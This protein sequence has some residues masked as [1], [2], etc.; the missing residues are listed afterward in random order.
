MQIIIDS[1]EDLAWNMATFQRDYSRS[2]FETR[3]TEQNTYV[4]LVNGDTLLGFPEYLAGNIGVIFGTLFASPIRK[5]KGTWD[6]QSYLDRNHANKIYR[7]QL[8]LY[9]RLVEEHS[10]EFILVR[11][12]HDLNTV[13]SSWENPSLDDSQPK[14][15]IVILMEG[16]EAIQNEDDIE[17][18]WNS[19]V[20][21][22]GPAWAGTVFCGGTR[23]PGALTKEG[24]RLLSKMNDCGFV[25]DISHMD[26]TAVMQAL[27]FYPGTIIAS[28]SNASA[29]IKAYS[30]NRHLS[31]MTI[32]RLLERDSTIGIIPYNVFLDYD[33]HKGDDRRLISLEKVVD[34]IDYI[35]QLAGDSKHV[36]IGTDFD[37][38]FGLQATPTELDSIADLQKLSKLLSD[39]GYD[40]GNVADILGKNW[41]RMLEYNLP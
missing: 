26:E 1:H 39:R 25:L 29:V 8:D 9:Y 32:L 34:Q 30:G 21:V 12:K 4:P 38:G 14:V 36:G 37:G 35:C 18:W 6:T 10:E 28:H 40:G 7:N 11:S 41:Q 2:A 24:F 3:R 23:E 17:E 20:R 33:W 19:G 13:L 16:A 15:G 5:N 27:D 31:D 22:I